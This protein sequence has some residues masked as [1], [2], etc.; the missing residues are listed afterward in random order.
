MTRRET[1]AMVVCSLVLLFSLGF[2]SIVAAQDGLRRPE[3]ILSEPTLRQMAS[4]LSGQLAHNNAVALAGYNRIRTPEEMTGVMFEARVLH[5]TMQGY[6]LDQLSVESL[7]LRGRK[8]ATWWVG[9]DG[10]LRLIAPEDRLLARLAEQPA[11]LVRGS[12]TADL[13]GELVFVDR[14]DV[15]KLKDM[16]FAGKIVLTSEYPRLVTPALEKGALGFI[17]YENSIRPL[18]DP[19]QVVFDMSLPRGKAKRPV[20][21]MRISTRL[22][23]Q[24]R[25]LVVGGQKVVVRMKCVSKEY[26]WK[27]D[28]LFAAIH[29][30]MPDRKGLMFTA[31]LFERPAK[32][33]AN[34]NISGCV[35]LAEIARTLAAM[36]RDGRIPRPERSIYFLMSEEGSGTEAFL[37]KHPEMAA[38]ILGDFNMDMVGENLE[39]NSANFC[40]ESPPFCRAT[41]LDAVAQNFAEYVCQANNDFRHNTPLHDMFS[42]A[43]IE[44]NG[45]RQAFRYVMTPFCGGSDHCMFIESRAAI[46]AISCTIWP[47]LWYHTD[48]DTADKVDPTQLKRSALIGA[49]SALAVCSGGKETL[50]RLS[51]TAWLARR[52]F[53][54]QAYAKAAHRIAARTSPDGGRALRDGLN[55]VAQ[56]VRV[57]Q[58]ALSSIHELTADKP[59]IDRYLQGLIEDVAKMESPLRTSLANYDRLTAQARGAA[60]QPAASPTDADKTI[61]SLVPKATSRGESVPYAKIFDVI[62]EQQAIRR[63]VFESISMHGLSEMFLLADGKHTLKEIRDLLSFEFQ[64]IESEDL[65]KTAK[66]LE[67]AKLLTLEPAKQQHN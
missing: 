60:P 21:G 36:I 22:G 50:E 45:S 11:L 63:K 65:L 13:K 10:E 26:P 4:E 54:E 34:D 41:Y 35:V 32:I 2:P 64:P 59:A 1:P 14:R 39:V 37:Q 66:A 42:E 57:S 53:V 30:T 58:A 23:L 16:D 67:A 17:S 51:R 38:K 61:A 27:A 3:T 25:Y 8:T 55:D 20:I 28:T 44:K 47:D 62:Y 7:S 56:A 49:G 48:K 52:R 6:G 46:P 5:E 15:P 9:H 33:G 29:G 12:D 31:H 19:D 40:I 24:L 18:E 43:I